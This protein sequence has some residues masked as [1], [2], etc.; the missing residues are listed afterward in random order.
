MIEELGI[1]IYFEDGKTYL[2]I[3]ENSEQTDNE[4]RAEIEAERAYLMEV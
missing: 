1:K 3:I 2:N 4:R